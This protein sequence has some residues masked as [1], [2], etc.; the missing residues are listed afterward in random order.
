MYITL[1]E[2]D[3]DASGGEGFINHLLGTV[4]VADTLSHQHILLHFDVNSTVAHIA[5]H[6]IEAVLGIHNLATVMILG[7]H[8][9]H[10]LHQY[11]A[12]LLDIGTISHAHGD[13]GKLVRV[14]ARQVVEVL[15]KERRV[16]E[17]HLR[18]L[19]GLCLYALIVDGCHLAAD[20]VAFNLVAHTQ[21]TAHQLD[22]VDEVVDDI[23]QRQTDTSRQTSRYQP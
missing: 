7:T 5:N 11:L 16:E 9:L 10:T 14:V 8:L 12:H 17:R 4:H 23:L 20:T 13:D 21:A 3:G 6:H 15:T 22:A 19:D 18:T 2:G 1:R